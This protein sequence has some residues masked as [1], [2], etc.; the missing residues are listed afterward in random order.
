MKR[1]LRTPFLFIRFYGSCHLAI[2]FD[3]LYNLTMNI[4]E[5][6]LNDFDT[7]LKKTSMVVQ[8]NY[9]TNSS[10]QD[11]TGTPS[12]IEASPVLSGAPAPRGGNIVEPANNAVAAPNK[13]TTNTSTGAPAPSAAKPIKPTKF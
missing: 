6:I 5:N 2:K 10:S 7:F 8:P 3:C 11:R 9:P 1:G 12:G 13:S 4:S